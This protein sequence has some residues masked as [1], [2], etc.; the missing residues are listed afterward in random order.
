MVPYLKF[1]HI[2]F[3]APLKRGTA[4]FLDVSMSTIE[5]WKD[6]RLSTFRRAMSFDSDTV[7]EHLISYFAWLSYRYGDDILGRILWADARN[8][9]KEV[10]IISDAGKY[11]EV[12]YVIK[13]AGKQNCI[14]IRVHR[15]G[16][17]FEGDNREY[18]P[19]TLCQSYD[20]YNDFTRERVTAFVLRCI[21]KH[22]SVELVKEPIWQPV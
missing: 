21:T 7:R 13:K 20:V 3:A 19:D 12:N 22:F 18:L 6:R 4:G 17:T 15:D 5:D 2:K 14:I 9:A 10:V 11:D 8:S 1:R 16:C